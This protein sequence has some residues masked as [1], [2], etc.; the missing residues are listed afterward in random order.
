MHWS[1]SR[2]LLVRR[3][4]A[5]IRQGEPA[6]GI[7]GDAGHKVGVSKVSK[8]SKPEVG[9]LTGPPARVGPTEHT[10]LLFHQVRPAILGIAPLT[11][12]V[13]VA[14]P[15]PRRLAWISLR[16]WPWAALPVEVLEHSAIRTG[17]FS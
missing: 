9:K 2:K 14:G 5:I 12:Q 13:V 4:R 15:C 6:P 3:T 11:P 7:I 17:S 1:A 10:G 16:N 8:D